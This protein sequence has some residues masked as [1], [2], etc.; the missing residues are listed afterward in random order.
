MQAIGLPDALRAAHGIAQRSG[1]IVLDVAAGGPAE[2]AGVQ[3]G[4]VILAF[5]AH[6]VGD[7]HD[8][9]RALA[10]A[11]PG[12]AHTLRLLRGGAPHALPVTIGERPADED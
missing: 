1:A 6:E 11:V 7:S 8:V 3:L 10:I 9:Q 4:D 2:A 12:T 5:G